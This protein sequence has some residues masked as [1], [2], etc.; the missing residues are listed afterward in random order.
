DDDVGALTNIDL[1]AGNQRHTVG[2]EHTPV[3]RIH[4]NEALVDGPEIPPVE[5]LGQCKPVQ[6]DAPG[7]PDHTLHGGG[8]DEEVLGHLG[9]SVGIYTLPRFLLAWSC[10]RPPTHFSTDYPRYSDRIVTGP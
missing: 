4:V 8:V 5:M 3:H 7:H 2:P 10:Q 1:G 9:V 6:A